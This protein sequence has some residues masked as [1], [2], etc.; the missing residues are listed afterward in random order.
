MIP[1]ALAIVVATFPIRERGRALAI[2][3]GV[4][5]GPDVDRPDCRRLPHAVDLAGRSSGSTSRS[6]SSPSYSPALRALHRPVDVNRSTGRA[7]HSPQSAWACQS[8]DS[9]RRR[10]GGW[11]SP[12]TIGCIVAGTIGIVVFVRFEAAATYPLIRVAIF[13]SRAFVVD[14][15]VLF[16]SMIAFVPVFF[17]ASVYSQVSL[18]YN[19]SK[20]GLYLLLF[21]AGFAPAAQIGGR[22]LDRAGAKR[23]MVL[24]CALATVGF[25]LW[26][27]SLT[28]LSLGAQWPYIL[29]SGAG[30]GLLL[31]PASTD[32]VNRAIGASYGEVTG[33]TQTIRNY[34]STL[35]IA[36]L[37]T[38]LTTVFTNHLTTSFAKLGVP[39]NVAVS[40]AHGSTQAGSGPSALSSAPAALRP[41]IS[42]AIAHDFAV[43]TQAVLYGMAIVHVIAF[44]IARRHPGGLPPEPYPAASLR[45]QSRSLSKPDHLLEQAP[46]DAVGKQPALAG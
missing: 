14:N 35:G 7:A 29:M 23:P 41:Q 46:H 31:G 30:I 15:L 39:K 43:A 3:F 11:R 36:V 40:I 32:A 6:P 8:S 20:A 9:S 37:G 16:F 38:V 27:H 12:L 34:G 25:A 28:H 26:A 22:M 21:F 2:F 5:G 10:R 13:R 17:F 45:N 42:A 18:G 4:S 1:A 19:A 24:G 44:I 33:I